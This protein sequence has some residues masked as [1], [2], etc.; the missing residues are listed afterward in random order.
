MLRATRLGGMTVFTMRAPRGLGRRRS[1]APRSRCISARSARRRCSAEFYQASVRASRAARHQIV[2]ETGKDADATTAGRTGRRGGDRQRSDRRCRRA[3]ERAADPGPHQR[4]GHHPGRQA[5]RRAAEEP[6][7]R[8][9]RA[10]GRLGRPPILPPDRTRRRRALGAAPASR[11]RASR[12]R[13]FPAR[14]S[15]HRRRGRWRG[16]GSRPP[17]RP[18]APRAQP[19]RSA[20]GTPAGRQGEHHVAV[21]R[22]RGRA[23]RPRQAVLRHDR[24][25]LGLGRGQRR[26]GGHAGDG[27]VGA[28]AGAGGP[29]RGPS[30]RAPATSPAEPRPPNS[31]PIS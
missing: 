7:D 26:V 4:R 25:P 19:R 18:A 23:D 28:P 11:G 12:A 14:P 16:P 22:A 20:S 21:E 9:D 24:Q 2:F 3:P 31:P 29:W 10:Q 30:R 27:G 13:P 5:E 6:A 1:T 15:P 8:H 17:G